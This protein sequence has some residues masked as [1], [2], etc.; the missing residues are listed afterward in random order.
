MIGMSGESDPQPAVRRFKRCG[1]G[2]SGG[3]GRGVE[4][5]S[6]GTLEKTAGPRDGLSSARDRARL[7][8][9]ESA[10][11]ARVERVLARGPREAERRRTD[12]DSVPGSACGVCGGS[13]VVEDEVGEGARLGQGLRLARC[14][15]CDHRWTER[16]A[17][18][19]VP[20]FRRPRGRDSEPARHANGA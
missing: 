17:L 20:R 14:R 15:R 5:G 7:R 1:Q 9:R 12:R 10:E 8:E 4:M 18:R 11:R 2:R 6:M 13:E 16:L 3:E 19:F